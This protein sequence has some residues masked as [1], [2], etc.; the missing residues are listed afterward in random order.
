[1]VGAAVVVVVTVSMK[2]KG[3]QEWYHGIHMKHIIMKDQKSRE[4]H[5]KLSDYSNKGK[6]GDCIP[7]AG[8]SVVVASER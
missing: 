6:L 8:A 2:K 4:G 3:E 5:Q 1:V 7:G